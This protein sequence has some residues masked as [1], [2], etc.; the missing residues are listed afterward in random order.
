MT[1]DHLTIGDRVRI[2]S[3]YGTLYAEVTQFTR[4]LNW[5]DARVTS[6]MAVVPVVV[7]YQHVRT[8]GFKVL[9][10]GNSINLSPRHRVY[11]FF[12]YGPASSKWTKVSS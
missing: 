5:Y 2:D 1:S 10:C 11:S 7:Y 4:S 3:K 12:E 8:L 9:T 6:G